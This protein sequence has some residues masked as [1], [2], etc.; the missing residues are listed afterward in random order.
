MNSAVSNF[1]GSSQ[2]RKILTMKIPRSIII[3]SL[4]QDNVVM[5]TLSVR[6][7]LQFSAALRLPSHMSS[8]QR[9]ERVER[10]I[11]ELGLSKCADQLVR[12]FVYSKTVDCV[13]GIYLESVNSSPATHSLFS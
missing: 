1:H 8:S 10:V 2:P 12:M 11:Q 9:R 5:G 6:E 4:C 3:M 7:N 13:I